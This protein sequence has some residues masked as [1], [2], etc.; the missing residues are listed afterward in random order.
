MG[1]VYKKIQAYSE[2]LDNLYSWWRGS[3]YR[4][5]F[6]RQQICSSIW[7][8]YTSFNQNAKK[9]I[10]NAPGRIQFFIE[11]HEHSKSTVEIIKN[12]YGRKSNSLG[13]CQ[14]VSGKT[15]INEPRE[16]EIADIGTA[17]IHLRDGYSELWKLKDEASLSAGIRLMK[18]RIL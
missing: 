9:N 12:G 18:S 4:G 10:I 11:Y 8:W 6:R 1:S 17:R 7:H 13:N 15:I 5:Y 3:F 2:I 16:S 14:Y